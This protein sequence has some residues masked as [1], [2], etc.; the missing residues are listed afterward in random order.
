MS[1]D[2]IGGFGD[3][4][5]PQRYLHLLSKIFLGMLFPSL[6]RVNLSANDL[7]KLVDS[8]QSSHQIGTLLTDHYGA[9]SSDAFESYCHNNHIFSAVDTGFSN[10]LVERWDQTIINRIRCSKNDPDS[11]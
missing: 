1:L 5:S 6:L 7:I 10:G 2:S 9:F 4:G 3:D 8:V 11:P